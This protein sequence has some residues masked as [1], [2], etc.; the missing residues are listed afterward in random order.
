MAD[1]ST[2]FPSG[3]DA[4]L[5]VRQ[6]CLTLRALHLCVGSSALSRSLASVPP[7]LKLAQKEESRGTCRGS[8]NLT[9]RNP[10]GLTTRK[11]M[12]APVVGTLTDPPVPPV[13][14]CQSTAAPVRAGL[15]SRRP[16]AGVQ[17]M[18]RLLPTLCGALIVIVCTGT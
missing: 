8:L 4:T 7:P 14:G 16:T 6:G 13:T 17:V 10:Y 11:N 12:A 15:A 5:Y 18:V 3:R 1:R 9:S 2:P